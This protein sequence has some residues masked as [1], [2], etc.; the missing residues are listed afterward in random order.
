MRMAVIILVL[1][2]IAMSLVHLRRRE[3]HYR[4]A[5]QCLRARKI[6][7][8]RKLWDQQVRLGYLTSPRQISRRMEEMALFQV[9]DDQRFCIRD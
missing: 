9:T 1:S 4:H 6:A 5:S 8:N 7:L 3:I 2:A